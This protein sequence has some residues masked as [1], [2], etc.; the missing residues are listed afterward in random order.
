MYF[1]VLT[2][3]P[4]FIHLSKSNILPFSFVLCI[5]IHFDVLMLYTSLRKAKMKENLSIC[6]KFKC[7]E[8]KK[9]E[10]IKYSSSHYQM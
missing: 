5:S 1:N 10:V 3:F 4:F 8:R 6:Q 7:V 2:N 9:F